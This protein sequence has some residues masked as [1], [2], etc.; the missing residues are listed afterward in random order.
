MMPIDLSDFYLSVSLHV[1]IPA[2][3]ATAVFTLF[4]VVH[5]LKALKRRTTTGDQGLIGEAGHARTAVNARS[6]RVFVHG[7]Y[8]SAT[9]DTPIEPGAPV[10][11]VRLDGLRLK[12]ERLDPGTDAA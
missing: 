5:A 8:W 1:V 9:S 2:V 12:V 11:V 6:G 4:A 7:E 3:I 10:R